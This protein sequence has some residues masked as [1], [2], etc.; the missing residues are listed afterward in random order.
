[1]TV[2]LSVLCFFFLYQYLFLYSIHTQ[3]TVGPGQSRGC[4]PSVTVDN[5][6]AALSKPHRAGDLCTG[7]GGSRCSGGSGNSVRDL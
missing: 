5:Q 6:A 7:G 4:S 1:M 2:E 3:C